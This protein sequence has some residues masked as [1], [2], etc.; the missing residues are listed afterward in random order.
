ML[1]KGAKAAD[2]Q[3]AVLSGTAKCREKPCRPTVANGGHF[4][5][6]PPGTPGGF[7][8]GADDR[9]GQTDLCEKP[10][11]ADQ[12]PKKGH[13][14]GITSNSF[15]S[16]AY[17]RP[18]RDSCASVM[19][20]AWRSQRA[21]LRAGSRAADSSFVLRPGHSMHGATVLSC[22]NTTLTG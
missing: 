15:D 2:A 14:R 20:A 3:T 4:E 5:K 13:H 18:H 6:S 10:S 16:T 21:R 12:R 17:S 19:S 22:R 8:S 1:K 7:L 9:A 11:G